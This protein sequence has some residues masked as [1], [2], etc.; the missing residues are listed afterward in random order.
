MKNK[1][2]KIFFIVSIVTDLF[3]FPALAFSY[4]APLESVIAPGGE[5]VYYIM[6]KPGT[7]SYGNKNMEIEEGINQNSS[8]RVLLISHFS[9]SPEK[10]LTGFSHLVL[11]PNAKRLYFETDAWATSPAIHA[12]DLSS[13]KATFVTLGSIACIVLSGEYQGDLIVQQHRYF[14]EGGSHDDLWLYDP[15]GKE[16][17]MVAE[18][19]DAS[20]VCPT[21]GN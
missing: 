6:L 4:S 2:T 19:T 16:I 11:S 1:T 10:N 15:S 17:G 3:L 5:H 12:I 8:F 21:L 7:D 9:N 14:I 18:G 20:K 13:G